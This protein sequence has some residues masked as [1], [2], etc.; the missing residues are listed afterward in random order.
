MQR[1]ELFLTAAQSFFAVVI[2]SNL[3][4]TLREAGYLFGLFWA[5]FIVG[6]LVPESMHGIERI[7]VGIFYLVL[8][9]AILARDRRR[10]PLLMRDAF[11][12]SHAE[13]SGKRLQDALG[14]AEE[15]HPSPPHVD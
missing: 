5:Q 6:A 3:S 7:S 8:G 9:V 11:V 2:M 4:L 1:E 15:D 12:A 14:E 13:L 10:I